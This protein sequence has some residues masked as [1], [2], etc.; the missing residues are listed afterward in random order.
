MWKKFSVSLVFSVAVLII[1]RYFVPGPVEYLEE[2]FTDFLFFLR[3]AAS[4]PDH[5]ILI[6]AIDEHTLKRNPYRVWPWY[7]EHYADLLERVNKLSPIT[8]VWT[9]VLDQTGIP[10]G[11]QSLAQTISDAG[12]V[13]LASFISQPSEQTEGNLVHVL[14][15]PLFKEK[16]S[17]YGYGNAVTDGDMVVRKMPL[18]TVLPNEKDFQYSLVLEAVCHYLG[19]DDAAMIIGESEIRFSGGNFKPDT[20][21]PLQQSSSSKTKTMRIN[22]RR[23]LSKFEL[24]SYADLYE[25]K[26][27]EDVFKDRIILVGVAL[28][29]EHETYAVPFPRSGQMT[30]VELLANGISTILDEEFI[31]RP[32]SW[33]GLI[34]TLAIAVPAALLFFFVWPSL[35]WVF[36][37]ATIIIVWL[38]N[39]LSFT[40]GIILPTAMPLMSI[41][42]L[43]LSGIIY[44]YT[45]ERRQRALTAR[46]F[47]KYV[48]PEVVKRITMEPELLRL[49]GE[50]K[51]LTL[52]F[53]D[54][55]GFTTVSESTTPEELVKLLNEY[56]DEMSSIILDHG[57]TIDKYIGDAMMVF[58]NAPLDQSD[59][60]V[61]ACR[62]ALKMQE[63]LSELNDAWEKEGRPRLET[64]IGLNTGEVIVGNM[65]S[66]Q[67]FDYTVLGDN[68]NL[69]SR[70]EGVNKHYGTSIIISFSTFLQTTDY[71]EARQLDYI[72]VK[73][74]TEPVAI[75]ELLGEKGEIL[76]DKK[77]L[78]ETFERAL[79][80]Y[81]LGNWDEAISQFEKLVEKFPDDKASHVFLNRCKGLQDNSPPGWEGVYMFDTK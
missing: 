5:R 14:P 70:L 34:Y 65:G 16:A 10:D 31:A 74:K 9:M 30:G 55:A 73:G 25:G 81:R 44:N 29:G 75:L 13:I 64:R 4:Q 45:G 8:I 57:G 50:K 23:G 71:I 17:G 1:V 41:S 78:S 3:G 77:V 60:A 67:R 62:A 32:R 48:S 26:V 46:A 49:G 7:R 79:L 47:Q 20:V 38:V 15:S 18:V 22:F 66:S 69:A 28:P 40:G 56:M 27:S 51:E 37:L 2:K 36:L 59:H 63:R 52:L 58:W 43:Y 11:D 80:P 72:K 6:V 12:N 68:V 61:R 42:L 35:S 39:L 54:I 33:I 19:L 76:K 21:I 24:I 53:S